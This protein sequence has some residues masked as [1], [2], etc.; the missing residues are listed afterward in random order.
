MDEKDQ[1]SLFIQDFAYFFERNK[2]HYNINCSLIH[3]LISKS[4]TDDTLSLIIILKP[5]FTGTDNLLNI[6]KYVGTTIVYLLGHFNYN[7]INVMNKVIIMYLGYETNIISSLEFS[8]NKLLKLVNNEIT[9]E[10]FLKDF[11]FKDEQTMFIEYISKRFDTVKI[12]YLKRYKKIDF[13]LGSVSFEVINGNQVLLINVT[14]DSD[15]K[16]SNMYVQLYY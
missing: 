4:D 2:L 14:S 15:K 8:C 10:E 13:R 3:S 7:F 5:E 9:V 12:N 16:S 1:T 11:Y 6:Y